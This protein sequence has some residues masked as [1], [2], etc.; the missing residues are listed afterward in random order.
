VH[1]VVAAL[2]VGDAAM[3]TLAAPIDTMDALFDPNVVKLV[4]DRSGHALYFSRAPVPWARDALAR[5]RRGL[6]QDAPL[7]RHIGLY[8]YRAGFL[9]HFAQLASTPL[10]RAEA[11]EQLRALEHGYRIRVAMSTDEF[12][13]GID[14]EQDL[15]RAEEYLRALA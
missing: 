13:P 1:A 11:L 3:A 6:P 5:D 4:C 7:L 15:V 9:R 12:P 14:T 2:A 10:E 8:A